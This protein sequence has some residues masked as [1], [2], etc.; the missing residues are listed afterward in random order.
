MIIDAHGGGGGAG[1]GPGGEEGATSCTPSK[2]FEQLDHKNAIS[3]KNREPTP[4]F[5]HNP[6]Y[7]RQPSKEL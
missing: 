2:D 3:H 7:P 1:G 5:S 4:R 6:K